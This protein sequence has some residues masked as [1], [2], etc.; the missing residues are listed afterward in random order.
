MILRTPIWIALVAIMGSAQV[1]GAFNVIETTAKVLEGID[2]G[3]KAAIDLHNYIPKPKA[4]NATAPIGGV[5]LAA[6]PNHRQIGRPGQQQS[7][8]ERNY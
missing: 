1:T 4:K 7:F 6:K 2:G 5:L 8:L 3:I